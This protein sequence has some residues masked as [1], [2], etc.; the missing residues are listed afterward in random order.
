MAAASTRIRRIVLGLWVAA[1]AYLVAPLSR[2][3]P[4]ATLA[5]ADDGLGAG[6][7][8]FAYNYVDAV[9]IILV[10]ILG[11]GIRD[12]IHRHSIRAKAKAAATATPKRA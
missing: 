12:V 1:G 3:I 11:F 4:I 10:F 2:A 8:A 6:G 5:S 7:V 9:T